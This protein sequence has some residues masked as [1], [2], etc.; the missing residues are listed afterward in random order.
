MKIVAQNVRLIHNPTA[1][2]EEHSKKQL[3]KLIESK[4]YLCNYSSSKSKVLDQI[5][6]EE[7]IIAVAGG[8]GT[9]RKT[10][11]YL[12]NKKLKFKRPVAIL[13][14][15]T[16]N[17]I[18]GSFGIGA[19]YASYI[20]GWKKAPKRTLDVGCAQMNEKEHYF[21]ESFGLGLFPKLMKEM[22]RIENP[23]EDPE[24]EMEFALAKLIEL[25]STMKAFACKADLGEKKI[26]GDFI[27]V[28][29]MNIPR[30]G[31]QLAFAPH[32]DPSDGY[33]DL[34]MIADN[35]REDLIK[36]LKK[37]GLG[38]KAKFPFKSVQIKKASIKWQTPDVRLD[39]EL[40][41][42][43]KKSETTIYALPAL[44]NIICNS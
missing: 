5:Q 3:V 41:D 6:T 34:V 39:D 33:L 18:A 38:K 36:Y 17:N 20:S 44:F 8:D 21:I 13:P 22:D 26:E 12:L 1:G 24:K 31:P 11:L 25:V 40:L 27:M 43:K 2:D 7:E 9:I 29:A 32:I 10:I 4:G 35:Q 42:L 23:Q 16:A 30:L 37:I 15:G 14:F 28:E 19:N